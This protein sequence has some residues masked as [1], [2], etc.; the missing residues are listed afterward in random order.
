[1]NLG[2]GTVTGNTAAMARQLIAAGIELQGFDI[3]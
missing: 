1:V 3:V 2:S